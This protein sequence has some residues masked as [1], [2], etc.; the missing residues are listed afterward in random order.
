MA[1][2]K[3]KLKIEFNEEG[4]YVV[5]L[6]SLEW[7]TFSTLAQASWFVFLCETNIRT[8]KNFYKTLLKT[9]FSEEN[10]TMG[11]MDYGHTIY[12]FGESMAAKTKST[13]LEVMESKEERGAKTRGKLGEFLK[14][15][16]IGIPNEIAAWFDR[17]VSVYNA[18]LG[19]ENAPVGAIM[20]L[21]P[22]GTGKA[23]PLEEL[24]CTPNGF[25]PMGD[26]KV[27]QN[28]IGRDGHPCKVLAIHPQPEIPIYKV[29]FVDGRTIECCG[30]HLWQVF[31]KHWMPVEN[32]DRVL[33]TIELKAAV[34]AKRDM[35]IPLC[36]PV[37]YKEAQL[38]IDPYLL[39]VFLGDGS[40]RHHRNEKITIS[41]ESPDVLTHV[42]TTVMA[43]G[44]SIAP[45][46]NSAV[47][48]K[49]SG[50][51]SH[52]QNLNLSHKYSHEKFIPQ[53]YLYSSESQRLALVQGLMD[54]DGTADKGGSISF[55]TTSE[56]MATEFQQLI[57]SLGGIARISK[58]TP[59][60]KDKNGNKIYGKTAYNV[61]IRIQF[62]ERL[63]RDQN[64][65]ARSVK[66]RQY[67][68]RLRLRVKSIELCGIKKAQCITVDSYDSL[69]LLR[70]Y[71]V[72]HN[73]LAGEKLAEYIHGSVKNLLRIDCGEF[74][75]EHEVAKLIGA[76]PGYLGH[77]ETTPMLTQQKLNATTSDK[78][79]LSIV[80]FDEIEKAAT[81]MVRLLLG[82]LDKATL[83]LGD[84][85]SVNFERSLVIFTS[86]TG[87]KVWGS[88]PHGFIHEG[89]KKRGV[90]E[91][92]REVMGFAK[93]QFSPEF[94]N[95]LDLVGVY[96]PLERGDI[97]KILEL[98]IGK[99]QSH[100]INRLGARSPI[101]LITQEMKNHLIDNYTSQEYG[102]RELKRG[103]KEK[104]VSP[105]AER[106]MAQNGIYNV[107]VDWDGEK[108][109]VSEE[110]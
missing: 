21:G 12:N 87:S 105:V 61:H 35:Y 60:Y 90:E 25:V 18:G 81:S 79:N 5:K 66:N 7:Y 47:D 23:V 36:D 85:T 63:F 17:T 98:E 70:D 2:I 9:R 15:N 99:T 74:Q 84:N 46:I 45:V 30:D 72:T 1:D 91:K 3:R 77:R 48:H 96:K 55:C 31:H 29:T 108:A 64:K 22:T 95:R 44:G 53:S 102:A 62:P 59:H 51:R 68:H 92:R 67:R 94:I 97:E 69:Y 26:I 107:V 75:M 101:L 20:L 11:V 43:A 106:L 78:S 109:V 93:K 8:A 86:N 52:I 27:G 33:S 14:E 103:L 6:N 71:V 32:R 34:D 54:T 83:K 37:Q 104:V 110:E 82:V 65:I 41:N 56:Q 50:F 73:T 28:V 58:K 80:V 24:V 38:P 39:G 40:F 10:E 19:P 16:I 42:Y 57:F 4:E 89:L 76:P 100:F 13:R 88:K 49:I